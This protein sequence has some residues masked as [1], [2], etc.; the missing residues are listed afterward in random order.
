MNLL[1][2]DSPLKLTFYPHFML[3]EVLERERTFFTIRINAKI[4]M[5]S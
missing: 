1:P 4:D 3:I 5:P 2:N